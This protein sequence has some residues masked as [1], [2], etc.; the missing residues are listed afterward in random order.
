MSSETIDDQL[1]IACV[2]D[3]ITYGYGVAT[4]RDTDS[5]PSVLRRLCLSSGIGAQVSNFG[6]NGA[7]AIVSGKEPYVGT[8]EYRASLECPADVVLLMLGTNDAAAF[9]DAVDSSGWEQGVFERDLGALAGRYS[10]L[11]RRPT[12]VL[13]APPCMRA[14]KWGGRIPP[15]VTDGMREGVRAVASGRGLPFVDTSVPTSGHPEWLMDCYH[16]NREGNLGIASYVFGEL[17]RLGVL[18]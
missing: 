12:V 6:H 5:Y 4:T 7:C 9:E 14:C 18:G 11:P 17:E 3:S 8:S 1:A 2:G 16:P 13:L 15:E 10:A